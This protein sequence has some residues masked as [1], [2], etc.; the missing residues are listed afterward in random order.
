VTE[1][2]RPTSKAFRPDVVDWLEHLIEVYGEPLALTASIGE[3]GQVELSH[4]VN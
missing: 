2:Y 3:H 4:K 1:P